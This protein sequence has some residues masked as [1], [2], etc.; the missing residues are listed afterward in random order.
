MLRSWVLTTR[1]KIYE[2]DPFQRLDQV[3]VG[4]LVKMAAP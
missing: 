3:G 2:S 4:K 1:T